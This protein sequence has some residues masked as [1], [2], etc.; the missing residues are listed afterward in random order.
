MD[1]D[2]GAAWAELYGVL[3]HGWVVMVPVWRAGER[4]WA[5]YARKPNGPRH[6]IGPWREAFGSTQTIALG[7]MAQQFRNL[8]RQRERTPGD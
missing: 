3:P 1:D 4:V 6:V 8:R 2:E 5:V 7:A